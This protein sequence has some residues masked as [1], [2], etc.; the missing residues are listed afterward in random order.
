M[1]LQSNARD[2]G[3]VT[4]VATDGV[5][6][7]HLVDS[8]LLTCTCPCPGQRQRVPVKC[9]DAHQYRS[10]LAAR[11]WTNNGVLNFCHVWVCVERGIHPSTG[12]QHDAGEFAAWCCQGT[13]TITVVR[14]D[15]AS[16]SRAQV[17]VRDV[18]YPV[19][20]LVLSRLCIPN[21]F[22]AQPSSPHR[23]VPR[24][25]RTQLLVPAHSGVIVVDVEAQLHASK[26]DREAA[27][28]LLIRLR[29]EVQHSGSTPQ[30]QIDAKRQTIGMLAAAPH[31]DWL[32]TAE[33]HDLFVV[34]AATLTVCLL[35]PRCWLHFCCKSIRQWSF[36]SKP[37]SFP[38]NN[39]PLWI[40]CPA[41]SGQHLID[42]HAYMPL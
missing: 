25:Q 13:S 34:H 21:S 9:C 35:W 10:S 1:Q 20:C 42:W 33:E 7:G 16:F 15:D 12:G 14:L 40:A 39:N 17:T 11:S 29:P 31:G 28:P 32:A 19:S 6:C 22:D 41:A 8:D 3:R 5:S 27:A 23:A 30:Q 18:Q 37:R 36:R 2:S 26:L 24:S 38:R 4:A